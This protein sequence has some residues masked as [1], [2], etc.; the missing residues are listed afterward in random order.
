MAQSCPGSPCGGFIPA[1]VGPAGTAEEE[2]A[3][4]GEVVM[5]G[6]GI[7]NC[8]PPAEGC[9]VFPGGEFKGAPTS[10]SQRCPGSP[11]AGLAPAEDTGL[12]L[13][14]PGARFIAV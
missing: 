6:C 8:V 9:C 5:L 11:C 12:S 1:G 10:M 7:F 13:A 3:A 4:A 2:E 14:L